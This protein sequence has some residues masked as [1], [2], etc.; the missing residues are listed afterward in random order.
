MKIVIAG[1]GSVGTHL[2]TLLSGESQDIILLDE[3][4]ER[5]SSL[6]SN[7]DLLTVVA[8]PTSIR[9]LDTAQV[10]T[11]DLF[12]AVTTDESRNILACQLAHYLGAKKTVARIDHYEFQTAKNK[13]FFKSTGI[14]SIIYP[15]LLAALEILNCLKFS[16]VRQWWDFSEG[17]LVLIGVKIRENAELCNIPLC[18]L[19]TDI[20]YHIVAIKRDNETL[21]PS[22]NDS[23]EP[24]DM[25]YFM[26]TK[27]QIPYIRK[28]AGKQQHSD[29]KNVMIMG[30][31]P[32]A[33]C[34]ALELSSALGIKI[35]EIDRE[36]CM[37]LTE[38]LDDDVMIINGDGRDLS[39][40]AAEGLSNTSAFVALTQNSETNILACL[41]AKR[42]GVPKTIAQVENLDYITMA[43]RLDISGVINKKKIAASHIYQL[44]LNAD[45]S[46]VKCLTFAN[47][48]VAE[49]IVAEGAKITKNLIKDVHL[50]HG[51]TIGGLIRGDEGMLVTGSSRIQAGDHVVV[52][53][54]GGMIKGI[55][56][57]FT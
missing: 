46:N 37:Q 33:V 53:C 2:A 49:F 9:D 55:E 20:P 27:P 39:L 6:E 11:A 56:R 13:D 51:V 4:E 26:T 47:A 1:A 28:I 17:A 21:I 10:G 19:G 38:K 3:S 24:G 22:G 7:F 18:H 48:D 31:S 8:S 52:F 16:W 25:V 29:I 57:Y 43:E 12:V 50:P 30:G 5:L 42:F 41:A 15:E 14:D 35:I 44:M 45:V 36:R 40:L 32:I 23:I 34:T 54:L